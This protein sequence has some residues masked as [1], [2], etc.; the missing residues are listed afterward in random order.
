MDD[1]YQKHEGKTGE[2]PKYA[3][4]VH[5]LDSSDLLDE[6]TVDD[7]KVK[8]KNLQKAAAKEQSAMRNPMSEET[9]LRIRE[10]LGAG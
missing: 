7:V 2:M 4:Y 3:L 5:I 8:I 9:F 10:V 6:R 1:F